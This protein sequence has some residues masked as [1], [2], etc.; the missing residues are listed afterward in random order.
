MLIVFG[1]M[2]LMAR[3]QIITTVVGNGTSLP[4]YT[5][6]I[7][8]TSTGMSQVT[9][10]AVDPSGNIY[11]ADYGSTRIKKVDATTGLVF[12]IAGGGSNYTSD[13][14][15]G[16]SVDNDCPSAVALDRLGNIY[17]VE[18]VGRIVRKINVNTGLVT[19]LAGRHF[20]QGNSGDDSLAIHATLGQPEGIV[21]DTA[22]NVYIT[23]AVYGRVRKVTAST[24]II[25]AFAGGGISTA[26]SIPATSAN[27]GMCL[28]IGIDSM[29]NV[30]IATWGNHNVRK[31][32]VTTNIITTVAG[33]GIIGYNGDNIPATTASLYYSWG[34]VVDFAGNVYIAD[35]NNHRVRKVS[36][37]TG[38]ISTIAGTGIAGYN[39][40]NI[41][42]TTAEIKAPAGLALD[43]AG[44][45]FFS[46]ELGNRIRKVSL[47]TKINEVDVNN[48]SISI[49]PN[50]ASK[51]LTI[52]LPATNIK[53]CTIN[54][55]DMLGEKMLPT[56]TLNLKLETLNISSLPQGIYFLEVLMDNEKVVRKVVKM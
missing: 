28:G 33:N 31:V 1:L 50:P 11:Y 15:P 20:I 32:N 16:D 41:L 45:L 21:I 7:S 2:G 44:N 55:Y 24:G 48:N 34:V 30:Y 54:L 13:S 6:S 49:F 17:Y 40:D 47:I 36:S 51:V 4:L 23:D 53:S 29:Q 42:A 5:D 22:G 37:S 3:A 10:I 38:L 35:R 43:A 18:P 39:G 19:I 12:T 8:A 25:S 14:I 56:H 26:D 52:S 27:L 9:G 46:E